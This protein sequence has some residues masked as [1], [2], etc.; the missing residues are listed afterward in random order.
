MIVVVAGC[1]LSQN[2]FSSGKLEVVAAENFWG[3]VAAQVGGDRVHVTSIVTNPDAD[4]H[5]YDATAADARTFARARYVIENG[6][7]Y[8]PWASKLVAGNPV[9][10][11]KTLD[12]GALVGVKEG[13]NPHLWYSPDYVN[14]V[15]DQLTADYRS[16]DSADAAYFDQQAA[17]YKASGLQDYAATVAAIRQKYAGVPVGATESIFAYL[18]QATGLNLLTPPQYMKAISEGADPS[19]A[20]KASA[21][22][23]V[24][25]RAIKVLVFNPQNSTP[26]VQAL[27]GRAKSLGIP[28][29][30]M[31]ETL[32]PAN[33]SFQ[34]WQT[35]Q[36][37]A[38]LSAL[39]G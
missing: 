2:A 35:R 23:Q 1:G 15:I 21:D 33:L 16:L 14:R 27:V 36:L 30:E 20:D 22:Q 26:D 19:A 18:A 4:P 28:V 10:G 7:G 8:D 38:L 32:A 25:S 11:R 17:S 29:V 12:V 37:K 31:T 5:A 34:Q 6:A 39:G 3:S 9:S 24:T 13:D